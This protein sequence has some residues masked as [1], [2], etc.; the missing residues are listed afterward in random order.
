LQHSELAR[1]EGK[2]IA[3]VHTKN[4]ILDLK[5]L[6]GLVSH[7]AENGPDWSTETCLVSLVC[8]L[9]AF[10]QEYSVHEV[11]GQNRTFDDGARVAD[12]NEEETKLASRYW[13]IAAKRLGFLVGQ[14]SLEA[15][16]CLCLTG[17]VICYHI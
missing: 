3:N 2:Y 10:S 4:P 16:Q 5:K 12:D 13:G 1:L 11:S 15:A 8:A 14:N 17:Y 9:G 6:H 7:L